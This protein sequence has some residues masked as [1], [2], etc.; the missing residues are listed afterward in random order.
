MLLACYSI[1]PCSIPPPQTWI[2]HFMRVGTLYFCLPS[3]RCSVNTYW[4][5]ILSCNLTEVQCQTVHLWRILT[6]C[7]AG[8]L[9]VLVWQGLKGFPRYRT[10]P[11]REYKGLRFRGE[12]KR[13]FW[14]QIQRPTC[15]TFASHPDSLEFCGSGG[16]SAQGETISTSSIAVPWNWNMRLLPGI[17]SSLCHWATRPKNVL[18]WWGR[19]SLLSR[20]KVN[21]CRG[22]EDYVWNP[23]DSPGLLVTLSH[24]GDKINVTTAK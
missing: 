20:E 6:H 24:T 9:V 10:C 12:S 14:L 13:D 23:G 2:V 22:S 15:K 5:N 7:G 21:C 19:P 11:W 1:P 18:Y 16:L 4:V 17:P 3:S 8:W